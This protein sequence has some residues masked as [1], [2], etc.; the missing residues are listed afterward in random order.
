MIAPAQFNSSPSLFSQTTAFVIER[1]VHRPLSGLVT[2]SKALVMLVP[3][4]LTAAVAALVSA[5]AGQLT[6]TERQQM[7]QELRHLIAGLQ[8]LAWPVAFVG[9]LLIWQLPGGFWLLLM[10]AVMVLLTLD[11]EMKMACTA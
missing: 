3:K 1:F 7:Q 9:F 6:G 10:A 5:I 4:L 2:I 8:Q 11:R